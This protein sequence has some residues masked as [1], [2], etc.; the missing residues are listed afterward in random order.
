MII[1][2]GQLVEIGGGFRLPDV[3]RSAGVQLKE[4]GTTNRTYVADYES[5][6]T[7]QTAAV[8]RVH[9]SNYQINGFATEP[10]I[11]D[12]VQMKRSKKIA[13]IDDLGSG[14]L[15][16]QFFGPTTER[17]SVCK[18][19]EPSVAESTLRGPT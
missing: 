5:A 1:S 8:M 9:H 4:I 17:D 2:R 7:D 16:T 10:M 18:I 11:A 6:V 19:Q 3:F 14:W 12:L 15:G 13:V